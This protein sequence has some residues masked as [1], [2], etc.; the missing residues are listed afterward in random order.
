MAKASK[1]LFDDT[2][3]TFGEHLEA[4]RTHVIKGGLGWMVCVIIAFMYS[5]RLLV[6]MRRPL[7]EAQARL[8]QA[9]VDAPPV[10]RGY[11]PR[12]GEGVFMIPVGALTCLTRVSEW[13]HELGFPV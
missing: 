5:D 13:S 4:L 2:A 6:L 11:A 1:D 7:D 10:V 12:V 3:M 8:K 9:A